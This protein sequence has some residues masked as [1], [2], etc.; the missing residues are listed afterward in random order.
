MEKCTARNIVLEIND[1]GARHL[2]E[3][4]LINKER[5]KSTRRANLTYLS[6]TCPFFYY[7]VIIVKPIIPPRPSYATLR[8]Y[9]Y[10]RN[11]CNIKRFYFETYVTNVSR[12]R[13]FRK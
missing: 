13:R 5:E 10:G 12:F 8:F 7:N 4:F 9:N 6:T 1:S 3:K 11:P 2:I